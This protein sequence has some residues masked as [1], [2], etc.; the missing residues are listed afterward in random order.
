[1][2][3]QMLA[4]SRHDIGFTHDPKLIRKNKI[5]THADM[6]HLAGPAVQRQTEIGLELPSCQ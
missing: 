4:H 1:M 3:L 2:P 6:E 5:V